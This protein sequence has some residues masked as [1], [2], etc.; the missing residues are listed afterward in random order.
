[1]NT[2]ETF[3]KKEI[4]LMLSLGIE[5]DEIE[6]MIKHY[7]PRRVYDLVVS[8]VFIKNISGIA[9]ESLRNCVKEIYNLDLGTKIF[10]NT[11]EFDDLIILE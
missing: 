5:A 8:M 10:R 6:F 7:T 1:M 9:V 11:K 2:D 4:Q 3:S